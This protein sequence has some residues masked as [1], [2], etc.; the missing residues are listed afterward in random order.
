MPL[1]NTLKI[2]YLVTRGL[3][4]LLEYWYEIIKQSGFSMVCSQTFTRHSNVRS[5][6]RS[7]GRQR[8]W[9]FSNLLSKFIR[10]SGV[11]QSFAI[12]FPQVRCVIWTP[13]EML[14]SGRAFQTNPA[15]ENSWRCFTVTKRSARRS[16]SS[17][18]I[19]DNQYRAD[20]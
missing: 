5:R 15:E 11:H 12:H 9:S 7:C 19:F 10:R 4:I 17:T 20:G 2:R 14:Q 3:C 8:R 13:L 1:D 6:F 16:P 18:L